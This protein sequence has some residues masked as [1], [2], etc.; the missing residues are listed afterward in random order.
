[1]DVK[2]LQLSHAMQAMADEGGGVERRRDALLVS[3]P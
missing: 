2:R 1:M 3:H